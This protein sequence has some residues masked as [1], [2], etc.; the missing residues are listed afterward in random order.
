[1]L[2][3]F[4][5]GGLAN[6]GAEKGQGGGAGVPGV[7]VFPT[8]RAGGLA[9]SADVRGQGARWG[10]TDA[11]CRA[12]SRAGR[13]VLPPRRPRCGP[14][15]RVTCP[16][17]PARLRHPIPRFRSTSGSASR[18]RA[19]LP[20]A[21]SLS[22]THTYVH[23]STDH[24]PHYV[25]TARELTTSPSH[26]GQRPSPPSTLRARSRDRDARRTASAPPRGG[27]ADGQ[28]GLGCATRRAA[29]GA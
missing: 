10:M 15:P 24:G 20:G 14:R 13:T 22:H 8:A 5:S 3:R 6:L 23:K 7:L 1:M 19:D 2:L 4:S 21:L 28:N 27:A 11:A 25:L 18:A 29:V 17:S 9:I 26:V 16:L 12:L